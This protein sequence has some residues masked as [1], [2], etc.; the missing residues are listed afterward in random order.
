MSLGRI[1][2]MFA[3]IV[4]LGLL[5]VACWIAFYLY[6]K[7]YPSKFRGINVFVGILILGPLL[8]LVH[9]Y[10]AK[11]EYQTTNREIWGLATVAVLL[12]VVIAASAFFG[13]GV[14]GN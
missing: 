8:P 12:L 9:A 7:R 11:R 5:G 13:V 1:D 2:P 14:R 4:G 3:V 10:L 6:F